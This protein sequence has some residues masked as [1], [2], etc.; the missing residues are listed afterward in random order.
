MPQGT[1]RTV[2]DVKGEDI[3]KAVQRVA[4]KKRIKDVKLRNG[5]SLVKNVPESQ[6]SS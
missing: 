3:T 4:W 1:Q 2:Q 5:P 6:I